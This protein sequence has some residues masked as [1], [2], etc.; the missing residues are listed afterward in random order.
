MNDGSANGSVRTLTAFVDSLPRRGDARALHAFTDAG[1][2]IISYEQLGRAVRAA[3]ADLRARG[4]G[5][6]TLVAVCAPNT[7]ESVIAYL[8]IIYAGAAA[9]PLD[10][11]CSASYLET[12]IAHARPRLVFTTRRRA[13]EVDAAG[14]DAPECVVLDAEDSDAR[15]WRRDAAAADAEPAVVEPDDLAS[16]LYTSGTTGNPKA[17]PLTHR[18]ITS[19]VEALVEAELVSERDRV[20]L[21]LPLHH[22]YPFTV[23]LLMPLAT[24]ACVVLPAG[25]S[26]PEISRASLAADATALLAVPRLCAVLWSSVESQARARGPFAARVFFALLRLSTLVRRYAGLR[27]GKLAFRP[28]HRRLGRRLRLIG[29]GGAKLDPEL[30]QRLEALGWRVLT[31]YGLTETSPVLTFNRPHAA[32]SGTEGRPLP[33]VDVRV[34]P[35]EGLTHGEVIARGPNV[36][37][38]YWGDDA[39]TRD[40]FTADGWFRTGDLGWIDDDGY[41]H[42]AGRSKEVIVLSDGKNVYPEEIEKVYAESPL[43][44][45]VAVLEYDNALVALVV[46][47]DEAVR[48]RGAMRGA[49]LFR[50]ALEE[51]APRLAP[52][53]R[54]STF[55]VTREPL[56]RTQLGKL[57]RHELEARYAAAGETSIGT[58]ARELTDADRALLETSPTREV[59]EWLAERFPDRELTLD[60]SPQ[61]D[62]G[63]DSLEWVSLTLEL[64]RR[65]GVAL[66]AEAVSRIMTLRELLDEVRRAEPADASAA[67][68]STHAT[69]ADPP[70]P[71][72][73]TLVLALARVIMRVAY[74]VRVTGAEHLAGD[75]P[76]VLTPNHASYLDPLALAAVLPWSRLRRTYWAGWVG[77]MYTGPVSRFLS[78]ATRVFP[79]DPDRD[80]AGAIRTARQL[81][82]SGYDVV[83]FPEGRRS[84][85]GELE[86]FQR[87]IGLLL[88]ESAAHAVPIG[89]HGTYA[90]WPRHARRP[91]LGGALGVTIGAPQSAQALREAG[92]GDGASDRIRN[93]LRAEVARVLGTDARAQR[94]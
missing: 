72:V 11:Q 79:V 49:A 77:K 90:A 43:F 23:G 32:K 70:I 21:P 1:D 91:R 24:G 93:A 12:V 47:D 10:Y 15:R 14:N 2:E 61:L 81:L 31:G 27:I 73:G 88:E 28:L 25:V 92:S 83:W 22:T 50:E 76:L 8:G 75:G 67:T 16:L 94:G 59:W 18:N 86:P 39:Q 48:E 53:Q 20:L 74:R 34:A 45:E 65:F 89:I 87:G 82:D 17:V 80:L 29:C 68:G 54:V 52:Y 78:R 85:S 69:Q 9:I 26:G 4:V 35:T 46:P 57:K 41:L 44:Q 62:L 38:G 37:A 63:V 58:A 33:G 5:R 66:T 84:T 71:V 51:L 30:E 60:T 55:R 36:F 64:E 13:A 40:V 3:A 6:G 19:N 42:I 56:P 7:A